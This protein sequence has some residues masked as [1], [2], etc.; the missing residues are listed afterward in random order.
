[1]MREDYNITKKPITTRNPQANSIVERAHKTVH[2]YLSTLQMHKDSPDA[3]QDAVAGYLSAVAKAIN[4]TVHTTMQATPTQL[5]FRR[6][7]FL[8][9]AFEAD[10][11]YIAERKQ[12]LIVQNNTR[13]N[14][15]R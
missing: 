1:M 3:Y 6:D 14:R 10:W 2:N 8:P 13:K 15:K 7:A 4:S 11:T 9:V 5:V 12:R